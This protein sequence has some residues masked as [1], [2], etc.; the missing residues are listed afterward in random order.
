VSYPA[1]EDWFRYQLAGQYV[2]TTEYGRAV[3]LIMSTFAS[4]PREIEAT[5]WA[6]T[7]WRLIK[8]ARA[9]ALNDLAWIPTAREGLTDL[10]RR[11]LF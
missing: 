6:W 4:R 3:R 8:Q 7:R 5:D 11:A 1:L 10:L 9:R 2:R